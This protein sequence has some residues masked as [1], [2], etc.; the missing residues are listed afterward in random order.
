MRAWFVDAGL[1]RRNARETWLADDRAMAV[2]TLDGRLPTQVTLPD[3]KNLTLRELHPSDEP[4]LRS[5]FAS[6]SND[7]RY[8]RFHGQVVELS[9]AAWRYLTRIDQHDH[10]GI[11]ALDGDELLGVARMIRLSGDND[12]AEIAFLVGD[13]QQRRRIGSTL[14][15]MLIAIARARGYRKLYAYVLPE[16]IA[17]R[18]LLGKRAV[19]RGGLLEL[20]VDA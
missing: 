4:M 10:V 17:I 15:D 5:W 1:P 3:G 20:A 18:K 13:E 14:R 7:A 16:N 6:L 11:L 8:H 12:V 19:D 2:L 9:P